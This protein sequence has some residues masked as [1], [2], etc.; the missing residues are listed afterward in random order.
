MVVSRSLAQCIVFGYSPVHSLLFRVPA[1]GYP[2]ASLDTRFEQIKRRIGRARGK[3]KTRPSSPPLFTANVTH[4]PVVLFVP[5]SSG[6]TVA[7]LHSPISAHRILKAVLSCSQASRSADFI[8]HDA[9]SRISLHAVFLSCVCDRNWPAATHLARLSQGNDPSD[10]FFFF[11]D[12][13]DTV[14]TRNF[15]QGEMSFRFLGLLRFP[16]AAVRS[17][18]N[19]S[20]QK[21]NRVSLTLTFDLSNDPTFF[22]SAHSECI[23]QFKNFLLLDEI[24]LNKKQ[25]IEQQINIISNCISIVTLYA[26][27]EIFQGSRY[28][29]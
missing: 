12:R 28:F 1:A 21:D 25:N 22:A 24:N 9:T 29:F 16:Q 2:L 7:Y 3:G 19:I 27:N 15:S 5:R 17:A 8:G 13:R 23:F 6:A 10:S 20:R 11:P 14:D 18:I 4:P 26:T